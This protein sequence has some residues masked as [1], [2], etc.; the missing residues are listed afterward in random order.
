MAQ[1]PNS[2]VFVT[3]PSLAAAKTTLAAGQGGPAPAAAAAPRRSGTEVVDIAHDV[4]T[5][6]QVRRMLNRVR[7]KQLNQSNTN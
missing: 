7:A 6:H 3:A 1:A 4:I 2:H 5:A